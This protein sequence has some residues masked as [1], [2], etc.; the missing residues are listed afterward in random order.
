MKVSRVFW[1]GT[2]I[3]QVASIAIFALSLHSII[4]TLT[5]IQ[6]EEAM[7]ISAEI[8][9]NTGDLKF[10]LEAKPRNQGFLGVNLLVDIAIYDAHENLLSRNSTSANI[11]PGE[12]QHFSLT[13]IIPREN[14]PRDPQQ[15]MKGSFEITF[16]IKTLGDL[17]GFRNTLKIMEA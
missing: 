11:D 1:I 5:G 13:L 6:S 15:E 14:L 17:V 10:L 12:S 9:E 4:G 7:K 2:V 3:F 16:D 8:D